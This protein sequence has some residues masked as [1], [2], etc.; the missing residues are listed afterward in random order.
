MFFQSLSLLILVATLLCSPAFALKKVLSFSQSSIY[1]YI[2]FGFYDMHMFNGL[3]VYSLIQYTWDLTHILLITSLTLIS[4]V[5][6]IHIALF[7]LLS[8]EGIIPQIYLLIEKVK[9]Q[10]FLIIYFSKSLNKTNCLSILQPSKCRRRHLL[11][12]QETCQW[13]RR[14][15]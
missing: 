4:T 1:I 8:W 2:C 11:L 3:T 10:R 13:L 7:S 5:L 14:C 6:L 12:I 15:S 9:K